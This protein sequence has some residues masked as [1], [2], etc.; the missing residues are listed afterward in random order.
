MFIVA[1]V[2]K[3]L[4]HP[5]EELAL[6]RSTIRRSRRAIRKDVSEADKDSFSTQDPLLL[7]WDGKL[8]PDIAGTKEIVDRIAVIVTG[9]G[10]EKL[11]A[12][13]KIARGTGEE[14]AAACI[15]TLDDWKIRHRIKG[16]V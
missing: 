9:H 5:L 1:S 14:Q 15:K 6:S 13:P 7:H 11:L 4:G 10:V 3:A 12:V 8:L 16:L 2:A